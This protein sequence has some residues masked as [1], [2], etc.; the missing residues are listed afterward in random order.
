MRVYFDRKSL[1]R[2]H[3]SLPSIL[4]GGW[5]EDSAY[6]NEFLDKNFAL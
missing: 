5:S 6:N 2:P 4:I 3:Y 1:L